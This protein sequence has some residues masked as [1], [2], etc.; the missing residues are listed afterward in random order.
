VT[1][2]VFKEVI[3]DD[4]D[5]AGIENSLAVEDPATA[6][7]DT[8]PFALWLDGTTDIFESGSVPAVNK[9]DPM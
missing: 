4:V 9:K 3:L 1:A 5:N 8:L 7:I 2:A 6:S